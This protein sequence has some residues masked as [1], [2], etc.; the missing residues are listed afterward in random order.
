MT[1]KEHRTLF[2]KG[3]YKLHLYIH[4]K[5]I[6]IKGENCSFI[7]KPILH[8]DGHEIRNI[9]FQRFLKKLPEEIKLGLLI[10][11]FEINEFSYYHPAYKEQDIVTPIL[12]L[13]FLPKMIISEEEYYKRL[14]H[15]IINSKYCPYCKKRIDSGNVTE[16]FHVKECYATF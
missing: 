7:Y 15:K 9:Y 3:S 2:R 8:I 11:L 12:N 13:E 5:V 6:R 4:S 1:Y 10:I 16:R 14:A